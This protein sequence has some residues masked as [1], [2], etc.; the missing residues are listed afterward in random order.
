MTKQDQE[1][2]RII[3]LI[4]MASLSLLLITAACRTHPPQPS[5]SM[6]EPLESLTTRST[7]P[8]TETQRPS[9]TEAPADLPPDLHIADYIDYDSKSLSLY[10]AGLKLFQE[11]STPEFGYTNEGSASIDQA[12]QTL[13]FRIRVAAGSV[14]G[15]LDGPQVS[16][17]MDLA[18]QSIIDKDFVAA[19]DFESLGLEEFAH[20][21]KMVIE[22][23]EARMIEIGQFFADLLE[24]RAG[25]G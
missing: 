3:R 23:D 12:A 8:A 22:L 10:M 21:S 5:E 2:P 13:D 19:P 1:T 20:Y 16:F 18:N 14:T 7:E 25:K 17:I 24:E 9:L 15:A 4:L 11:F 6:K